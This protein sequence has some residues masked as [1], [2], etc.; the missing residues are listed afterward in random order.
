MQLPQP[1]AYPRRILLAVTGLTPQVVTETL[2][3]LAHGPNPF[4]P[5]EV[6]LVTTREGAERA[7]LALLSEDPG[8]FARLL[9][10]YALP[11]IAFSDDHIHVLRD[12]QGQP[13]DDI[14]TL[15]DNQHAADQ[16]TERV[17][18][19]TA[20]DSAALHV[21]IAGGRKT[22]GYYLGYALSLFGRPQDRL[23]HVLV[24]E[25]FES[26]WNFFY[27]TPYEY[28]I[29]VKGDKLAD[30]RNARVDLADIPFVRLRE[31]LPERFRVGQALFSQAVAAANRALLPPRLR[32]HVK[33][34]S[35]LAD[36][37]TIALG[38]TEFAVLYWLARRHLMREPE[39][40]WSAR[41]A[42]EDFL[43][44]A[45]QV[46][47][48][49]SG[50]Y[51][52]LERAFNGRLD[53]PKALGEYFEPQKSRINKAFAEALGEHAAQRYAIVR[54]GARGASRYGLPLPSDAITI[55]ETT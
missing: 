34:R 54:Y 32:L 55:V 11:P 41:E 37:E 28:I 8:W 6:H 26:S 30:C 43:A 53:D 29:Q 16:I 25:P 49:A 2:Y 21:S 10:D 20:D 19:L 31:G 22:M 7:R 38:P 35:V 15:Q 39:V 45:R 9:R 24:S 33:G 44:A 23:S 27:P 36:E 17:R 51:E 47:N 5:T 52:R 18:S 50:E 42:A 3:A 46:M 40:E 14:R 48:H 13:L 12:A 1:S 4:L